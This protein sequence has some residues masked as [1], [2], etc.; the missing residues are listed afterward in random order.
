LNEVL[1]KGFIIGIK[2]ALFNVTKSLED[3][4]ITPERVEMVATWTTDRKKEWGI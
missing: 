2:V 3:F 4:R 1:Q